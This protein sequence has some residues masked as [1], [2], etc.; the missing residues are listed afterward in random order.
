MR[1]R[2]LLQAQALAAQDVAAT[3]SLL[4]ALRHPSGKGLTRSY[5]EFVR[6]AFHPRY[7][8]SDRVIY[9][10]PSGSPVVLAPH[11]VTDPA[12]T[13]TLMEANFSLF[14][15]VAVACRAWLTK[16]DVINC[17]STEKLLKW[18]KSRK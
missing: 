8:N 18:L 14:Y 1:G 4:A 5:A 2:K 13:F 17:W 12:R 9:F 7:W 10:P 6:A 3:D 16:N 11:Q 15:G